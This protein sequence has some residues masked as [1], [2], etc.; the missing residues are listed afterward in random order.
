MN[1]L[2]YKELTIG[3]LVMMMFVL[4]VSVGYLSHRYDT[5]ETRVSSIETMLNKSTY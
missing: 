3:F 1:K 2:S 4:S 5:M